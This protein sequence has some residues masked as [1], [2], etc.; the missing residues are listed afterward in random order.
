MK[1]GETITVK[2]DRG[3]GE[4]KVFTIRREREVEEREV[5][6]TG[7]PEEI[8]TVEV[9][10]EPGIRTEMMI[11]GPVGGSPEQFGI[12]PFLTK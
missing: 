12:D 3:Y 8:W 5:E 9:I 2:G 11:T 7:V 10:G 4:Y 6:I 1:A